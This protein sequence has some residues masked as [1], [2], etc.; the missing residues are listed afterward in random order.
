MISLPQQE[1][2]ALTDAARA[3]GIT[4]S[5]LARAIVRAFLSN[6]LANHKV[7]DEVLP[8]VGRAAERKG[9]ARGEGPF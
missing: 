5:Q 2:W 4:E 7:T 6:L 9:E 3:H 8:Y 1:F